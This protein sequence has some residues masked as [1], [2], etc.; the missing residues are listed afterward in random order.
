MMNELKFLLNLILLFSDSEQYNL[1]LLKIGIGIKS[2]YFI[3]II[4]YLFFILKYIYIFYK[5]IKIN[6]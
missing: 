1:K 5:R 6:N 2:I 4:N 3:I